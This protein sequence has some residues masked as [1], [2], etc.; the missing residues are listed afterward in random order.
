M[1]G[2]HIRGI[3]LCPMM[4][5][6]HVSDDTAEPDIRAMPWHMEPLLVQHFSKKFYVFPH[7]IICRD[8]STSLYTPMSHFN[9]LASITWQ[10]AR[11]DRRHS[12]VLATGT[13][14][15]VAIFCPHPA[16]AGAAGAEPQPRC[17]HSCS[18]VPGLLC[19]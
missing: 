10:L 17:V 9:V 16:E 4:A 19:T 3:I 12:H 8:K 1:E 18:A 7:I 14:T 13:F 15:Y 2:E 6:W 11:K 5:S